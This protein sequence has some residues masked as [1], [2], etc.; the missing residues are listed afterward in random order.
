MG[1]LGDRAES[2]SLTSTPLLGR[3]PA[4]RVAYHTILMANRKT[5]RT[6]KMISLK[7]S[8][9]IQRIDI[10]TYRCFHELDRR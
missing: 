10:P 6:G 1:S 2:G 9:P 4:E 5:S 7:N 8:E 3:E